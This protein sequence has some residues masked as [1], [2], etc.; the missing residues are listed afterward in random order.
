MNYVMVS[1]SIATFNGE[2][3]EFAGDAMD[4]ADKLVDQ[5]Y[6]RFAVITR[7]NDGAHVYSRYNGGRLYGVDS[8]AKSESG[9][10][11]DVRR[12]AAASPRLDG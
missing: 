9:Y 5:C 3:F 10:G 8:T 2:K 7:V 11:D 4:F 1:S 12:V 6:A